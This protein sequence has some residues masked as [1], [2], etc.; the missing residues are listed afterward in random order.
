[1]KIILQHEVL[2]YLR[3]LWR[4]RWLSIGL[5][6][7]ICA[8]GWAYVIMMP[9]RYEAST[10]VYL[11]ADQLLTPLLRGIAVDDNP[12]RQIDYLQRTLLSRPNLEQVVKLSN[13]DVYGHETSSGKSYEQLLIQL[14]KD[15]TLRS[16]TENLITIGYSNSNPV[17][18][19]DVVQALLTVFSENA[20]GGNRKQM[21]NAKRFIAQELQVYENGL[22]ATERRRAEFREK[23]MD[24]LP[25]L[26]GAVSHFEAGRQLVAALRLDAA[27]AQSKRDSL[28]RELDALPKSVSVDAAGPQVIIAGQPVGYQARIEA[29]RAKLDELRM[30]YTDQH[31]DVV[32]LRKQI[33]ELE[34]K[35]AREPS[36]SSAAGDGPRTRRTQIANPVYE[37]IK[38]R[39]VEAETALASVERRLKQ[40]E[41]NQ[42]VLEERARAT[43]GV[44]AQAEDLDRDYNVK[45]KN[46]EELLQRREQTGISEA[47]DTTADKI[48][49]RVI[50]PPQIPAAPVAPN[51]PMLVS[52]VFVVAIGA[53]MGI[54]LLFL[55]FDKSFTTVS[56]VRAL[57]L[58][59]LGSVSRVAAP[60]SRRRTALQIAALC[61][62]ASILVA[63][64]AGLLAQSAGLGTLGLT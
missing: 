52:A 35:A 42:N 55:Q 5:A 12:A 16:Q 63:I 8:I 2:P 27:D 11:N 1:M 58:P 19:K 10:R 9:P 40:A 17:L 24:L 13:F 18:A 62:T 45:R 28:Q 31:P 21:E 56:S 46:F 26:D 43:P 38:V 25:G 6:S 14:S 61:A 23:Y 32:A 49:F 51:R 50:D 54:P 3:Q 39:L 53:A 29:A 36:E 33:S 20:T 59:V 48:Q 4:Y 64:Y 47:A 34:A 30:R 7:L 15:V 44:Q 41:D 57:G 37:Q 60:G 22:R